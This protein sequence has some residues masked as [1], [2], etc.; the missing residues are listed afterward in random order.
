MAHVWD[1]G[2]GGYGA[3]YRQDKGEPHHTGGEH[4]VSIEQ[5]LARELSE[6]RLWSGATVE[7]ISKDAPTL[8]AQGQLWRDNWPDKYTDDAI[9]ARSLLQDTCESLGNKD[10]SALLLAEFGFTKNGSSRQARWEKHL[11][12]LS[13][14]PKPSGSIASFKRWSEK[15]VTLLAHRIV[16]R[17]AQG[18]PDQ[19]DDEPSTAPFTVN[20]V[21]ERHR[22]DAKLS[23]IDV[24]IEV[25]VTAHLPGPLSY[26]A[27]HR[28]SKKTAGLNIRPEFGC[29]IVGK[30][31]TGDPG[32]AIATLSF[33][34]RDLPEKPFSFFYSLAA[35]SS[36]ETYSIHYLPDYDIPLLRMQIE[37]D[38]EESAPASVWRFADLTFPES[39]QTFKRHQEKTDQTHPRYLDEHWRN[40]RRGLVY[41]IDWGFSI[42]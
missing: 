27:N 20:Y 35:S 37:F 11:D 2:G 21:S 26:L 25:N 39:Q 5:E 36:Q 19:Y 30:V 4:A 12:Q 14:S 29:S 31:D 16:V 13:T 3:S 28:I 9:A 18:T 7:R 41:G 33:G 40:L 6:L 42:D 38:S 24:H 10:Y 1:N 23:L 17:T 22:F 15:A 34:R 32:F 8:L